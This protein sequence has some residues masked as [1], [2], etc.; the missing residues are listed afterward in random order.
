MQYL[1]I[2]V[3]GAVIFLDYQILA[4][5]LVDNGSVNNMSNTQPQASQE[6]RPGLGTLKGAEQSV[7]D[8]R[9]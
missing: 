6:Q 8:I 5:S 1:A 2:A 3:F 7:G 9:S 4:P